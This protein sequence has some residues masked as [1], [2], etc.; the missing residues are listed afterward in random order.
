MQGAEDIKDDF[1]GSEDSCGAYDADPKRAENEDEAFA[2]NIGDAAPEE[3]EAPKGQGIGRYYP[4]LAGFWDFQ[5]AA[6]RRHHNHNTLNSN[7]L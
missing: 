1:V 2:V 7:S 3:E 4:L 5:L 6:K